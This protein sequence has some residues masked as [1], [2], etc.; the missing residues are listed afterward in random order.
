MAKSKIDW[1]DDTWNPVSGCLHGCPYCYAREFVFR[2]GLD[3]TG[4][5][6]ELAE[7]VKGAN[8]KAQAYPFGFDPTF[9]EYKLDDYAG[10]KK[11]GRVIFVCSMADLFG[12]WVPDEWITRVFRACRR[13][14]QH[15]YLF[16]TKNPERYGKLNDLGLLPADQNMFFGCTV[17]DEAS[18][19]KNM[20]AMRR[21]LHFI[22]N[23]FISFEPLHG[24]IQMTD[25]RIARMN[26]CEWVIIGAETGN[27]IDRIV[28]ERKW[29]EEIVEARRA[30]GLPVFMKDNA[31]QVWGHELIREFPGVVNAVKHNR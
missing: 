29:M 28:P 30:P 15:V 17:T 1:C 25:S 11:E 10:A 27:R 18:F 16:L 6:H 31:A 21:G 4:D 8:G 3:G 7:P 2:F 22:N 23:S 14:P 13:A 9:Y 26:C 12:S 20:D 5:V 19:D 24:R